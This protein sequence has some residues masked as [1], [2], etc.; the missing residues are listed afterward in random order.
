[1]DYYRGNLEEGFEAHRLERS[2]RIIREYLKMEQ[3]NDLLQAQGISPPGA[4]FLTR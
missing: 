1:V 2:N 3:L 4:H